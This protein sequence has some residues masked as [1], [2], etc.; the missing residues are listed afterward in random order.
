MKIQDLIGKNIGARSFKVLSL[1]NSAF[2]PFKLIKKVTTRGNILSNVVSV[3]GRPS[4]A[5]NELMIGLQDESGTS[6]VLYQP[7]LFFINGKTEDDPKAQW[8]NISEA[9]IEQAAETN[10]F[11]NKL[12]KPLKTIGLVV[13]AGFIL[14]AII[15]RK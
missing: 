14:M 3:I 12:L 11:T 15:K 6:W 8:V 2:P 7:G 1:Y 13:A 4:T 10:S 5:G 9:D